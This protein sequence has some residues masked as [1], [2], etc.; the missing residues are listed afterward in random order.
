MP[1]ITICRD[2]SGKLVF[3]PSDV[4]LDPKG[5]FV[6]FANHDPREAHHP[7][8]QGKAKDYWL[9]DPLP[10]FVEGQP[11]ATSPVVALTPLST[12]VTYPPCPGVLDTVCI[13]FVDGL[14]PDDASGTIRVAVTPGNTQ[15]GTQ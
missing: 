9:D 2:S 15:G 6:S 1:L 5:D 10:P 14:H 7:T 11:A 12:E 8:R 3:D 13:T 4:T